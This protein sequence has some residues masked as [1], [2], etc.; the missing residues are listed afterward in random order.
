[1]LLSEQAWRHIGLQVDPRTNETKKDF[2]RAHVAIDC[3]ISL[4]EKIE[5]HL[6]IEDKDR[7]RNLITDLQ[8]NYIQQMK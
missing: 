4:V 7:F 1:M 3:M 6:T 2:V 5:P 8:I